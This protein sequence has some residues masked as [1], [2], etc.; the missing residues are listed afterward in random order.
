[1][2][3][4]MFMHN[5][6]L[7]KLRALIDD[8]ERVGAL[9]RISTVFSF[10][11][12]GD[13]H[14]RNIRVNQ[15]LEPLGCLGDLG[16]YPLRFALWVM[17]WQLPLRVTGRIL[18]SDAGAA[19]KDFSGELFFDGGASAG[20]HCSFLAANQQWAHVSGANG[21]VRVPDFVLP[22]SEVPVAWEINDAPV[23]KRD[24]GLYLGTDTTPES[25]E[26]LMFR[27]F[28]SQVRLGV[29][30]EEWFESAL[31]TQ[32]V[33]DACMESARAGGIPVM[34]GDDVRSL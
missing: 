16:W 12:T 4:V 8:P 30:N 22:K 34:V 18:A 23:F 32:Q 26:A 21:S 28:A 13:F 33:A 10:L 6:R 29:L 17:R 7:E 9:Q 24:L 14:E 19:P 5:P 27:N 25:Q 20:F 2:D 1:M 11:G 31:K 3:G 15:S